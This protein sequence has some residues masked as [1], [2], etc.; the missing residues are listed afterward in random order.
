MP[1]FYKFDYAILNENDEIVDSSTSGESL[2]FVEGDGSMIVGLENALIGRQVGDRFSVTLAPEEAYGYPQ[3]QLVRTISKD[4]VQT[5]AEEI[6]PGMIFQVGSGNAT[7]VVKV[8][9]VEE[10]GITV[11]GNHPLAGI[12]FNFDISVL[13]VRPADPD[14][15]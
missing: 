3:R 12:T 10:D 11:D 5:E 7:E 4:M 13:E 2:S 6:K 15:T 9:S 14:E 1:T 8:V